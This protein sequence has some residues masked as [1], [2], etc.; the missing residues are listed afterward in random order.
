MRE[1]SAYFVK[2]ELMNGKQVYAVFYN[3]EEGCAEIANV[4]EMPVRKYLEML[5][6]PK[7]FVFVVAE[8]G[9]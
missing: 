4:E 3:K 1:I 7:G 9:E 6:N 2:D 8:D 5:E